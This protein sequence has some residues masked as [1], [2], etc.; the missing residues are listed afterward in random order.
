MTT[1]PVPVID[2]R[3]FNSPPANAARHPAPKVEVVGMENVPTPPAYRSVATDL[4]AQIGMLK[5]GKAVKAEFD[6]PQ[7]AAYV[8]GKL[9]QLAKVDGQFVASSK[10]PDG[11]TMWFWLEKL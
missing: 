3:K 7:H 11:R 8:R 2:K 9:R 10:L 5:P 6:S 4:Y 1:V